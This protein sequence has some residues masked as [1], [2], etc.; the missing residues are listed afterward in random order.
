MILLLPTTCASSAVA[1]K[2]ATLTIFGTYPEFTD[3]I[4]HSNYYNCKVD[5]LLSMD[6][7]F[8]S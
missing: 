1:W 3:E 2:Q 5:F 7:T 6:G 4:Q 8:I